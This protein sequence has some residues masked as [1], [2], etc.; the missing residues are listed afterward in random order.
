MK[1][2]FVLGKNPTLSTTE[3]LSLLGRDEVKYRLLGCSISVLLIETEKELDVPYLMKE[4]GGTIKVGLIHANEFANIGELDANNLIDAFL[5]ATGKKT[6]FGFSLYKLNN[7]V[8]IFKLQNKI[9]KLG[10]EI[11]N[12]LKD[13]GRSARLVVAR[14]GAELSSVI[15]EKNKLLTQGAEIVIL[16]DENKIYLGQTLAVQE[17]EDYGRR[18]FGRPS[19]DIVSG[20]MPPKL[21]K[22]MIN[23]AQIKFDQT[24]LDP[25]CGS[26]TIISE[27]L[28][29]GYQNLIGSD[30]SNKAIED[31]KLNLD[32]LIKTYNLQLTTYNLILL[33][34]RNISSQIK[35]DSIDAIVTEPY[36]GPGLRASA[37]E[38]EMKKIA[39]ELSQLYLAVFRNFKQILKPHGRAIIIFPVFKPADK[40][41]AIYLSIVKEIKNL[42][43]RLVNPLP[44]QAGQSTELNKIYSHFN[45]T[46]RGSIIYSRPDQ[47]VLREIFIWEKI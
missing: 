26:G 9:Y 41:Q 5:P 33:D 39:D 40:H 45:I 42:G 3:I 47:R 6:F 44:T 13:Q 25:F 34:A 16:A 22:M 7:Q 29:M 12:H 17:F 35:S 2:F 36:L 19:R 28:L 14:E 15:V 21:A 24:L 20:V 31:S 1:Y 10:L 38:E 18:D 4:L 32:W 43:F 46:D 30:V 23:L 27:A 8:N 37:T 11:K